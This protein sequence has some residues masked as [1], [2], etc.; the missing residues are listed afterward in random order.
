LAN[1]LILVEVTAKFQRNLRSLVKKYRR[2]RNDIQPIIEQLQARE[3]AG[4]QIP[5]VGYKF[6]SYG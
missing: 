2:I 6:L 5:G 3:L 4:D 1:L